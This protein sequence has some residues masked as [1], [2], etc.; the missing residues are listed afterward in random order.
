MTQCPVGYNECPTIEALNSKKIHD[1]GGFE[2]EYFS[3]EVAEEDA[4]KFNLG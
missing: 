3:K 4:R 1:N 2:F